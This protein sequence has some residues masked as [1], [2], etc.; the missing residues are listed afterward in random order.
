MPTP[1]QMEKLANS[2]LRTPRID[3]PPPDGALPDEY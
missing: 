2:P 3:D 1:K